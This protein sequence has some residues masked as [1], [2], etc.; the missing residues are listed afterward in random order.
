MRH[1][2]PIIVKE[3]ADYAVVEY[4]P[5][6]RNGPAQRSK[7]RKFLCIGGKFDGQRLSSFQIHTTAGPINHGYTAFNWADFS[8]RHHRGKKN[9]FSQIWVHSSQLV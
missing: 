4:K 7:L 9:P 5:A 8:G 1:T 3:T 2:P 6:D